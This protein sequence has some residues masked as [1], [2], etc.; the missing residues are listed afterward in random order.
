MI[1]LTTLSD[2]ATFS[3]FLNNQRGEV[4]YIVV[5]SI[6]CALRIHVY[7]FHPVLMYA[8]VCGF[9]CVCR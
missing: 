5:E 4:V 6:L 8:S 2:L 9:Y 3:S 1:I 7:D